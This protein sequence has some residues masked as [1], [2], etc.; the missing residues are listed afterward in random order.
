MARDP[1]DSE[2]N[3]AVAVTAVGKLA[4]AL[5]LAQAHGAAERLAPLAL[6]DYAASIVDQ[7]LDDP[8][9]PT[10]IRLHTP[11]VLRAAAIGALAELAAAH[12]ELDR[13]DVVSA[14]AAGL[15]DGPEIVAA[16]S[17]GALATLPDMRS[18]VP[19]EQALL[20]ADRQIRS[21]ALVAWLLREGAL[22]DDR[23]L[24]SLVR[25]PDQEIRWR[26]LVAASK[27]PERG[28]ALLAR[29][30]REDEDVY[31]RLVAR[32]RAA[33]ADQAV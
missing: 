23:H 12:P 31:F 17:I 18:P 13:D 26:V 1:R 2:E 7:N 22:P 29:I 19:L 33:E 8:L 25:D 11:R 21:A 3:R 5:T 9:S 27:D 30:E 14:V 32:R 16:A 4:P 28:P 24:E 15:R 6:G 20:A 10:Q